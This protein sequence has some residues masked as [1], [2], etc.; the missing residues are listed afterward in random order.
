M[1]DTK[2]VRHRRRCRRASNTEPGRSSAPRSGRRA[3]TAGSLSLPQ[4]AIQMSPRWSETVP[5][6]HVDPP[7]VKP[8]SAP[9]ADGSWGH[10]ARRDELRDQC[11]G[12]WTRGGRRLANRSRP[13]AK[14]RPAGSSVDAQARRPRRP[15]PVYGDPACTA[16]RR[17]PQQV[18]ERHTPAAPRRGCELV[19]VGDPDAA[20]VVNRYVPGAVHGHAV[21]D[22]AQRQSPGVGS[23]GACRLVRRGRQR[24]QRHQGRPASAHGLRLFVVVVVVVDVDHRLERVG[25]RRFARRCRGTEKGQTLCPWGSRCRRRPTPWRAS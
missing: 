22:E 12:G 4:F 23:R 7:C 25:R 17:E 20:L 8:P 14:G 10:A 24:R 3:G 9:R 18:L 15:P 11:R 6:G 21:P 16:V 5:W 19:V 13:P 2:A 1:P